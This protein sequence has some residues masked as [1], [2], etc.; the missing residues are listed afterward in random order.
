MIKGQAM[1]QKDFTLWIEGGRIL[2]F[3]DIASGRIAAFAVILVMDIRGRDVCVAR[4]DSAHGTPHRD[5][6]GMKKGLL[7]KVWFFGSSKEEVFDYAI[8]DFQANAQAY[9]RQFLAN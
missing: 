1:P 7:E 8:R 3:R 2:T 6:E 4:Y 9:L 5:T